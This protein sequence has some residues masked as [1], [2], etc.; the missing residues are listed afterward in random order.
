[1]NGKRLLLDT[2][3]VVALLRGNQQVL[4]ITQDAEWIGISIISVIEFLCFSGL[5]QADRD[6]FAQ[7]IAKVEV[8]GLGWG[9]SELVD[10]II[11][12]RQRFAV[13]LPDAII[14][15]T[16]LARSALLMTADRQFATIKDLPIA[17][18]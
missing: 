4:Q 3:A 10:Q 12:I 14:A 18:F 1:M 2:N 8:I 13:K 7:F 9:D 5:A 16:A 15:A 17:S 11:Q 6:L